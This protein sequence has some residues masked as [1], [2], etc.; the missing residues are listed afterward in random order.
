[1]NVINLL[2]EERTKEENDIRDDLEEEA[3]DDFPPE[4]FHDD[5]QQAWPF[6]FFLLLRKQRN[7]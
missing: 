6:S 2:E 4:H 5:F 1:M 7:S 3:D